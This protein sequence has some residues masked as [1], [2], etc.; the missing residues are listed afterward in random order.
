[1]DYVQILTELLAKHGPIKAVRV[2]SA[3]AKGNAKNYA[4]WG[5]VTYTIRLS[6]DG[7]PIAMADHAASSDRRTFRGAE[8]DAAET[9]LPIMR[10]IG[11][12]TE[13][14]ARIIVC[15]YWPQYRVAEALIE[16]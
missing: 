15:H 14:S 9:G 6:R 11:Q 10:A 3:K 13:S 2:S 8:R 16:A 7:R 1:M 12:I 5:A 4:Y